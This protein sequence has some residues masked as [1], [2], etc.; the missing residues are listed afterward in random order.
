MGSK[1]SRTC[2]L[3][4]AFLISFF[5]KT[6]NPT[7]FEF[8]KGA[9]ESFYYKPFR[10]VSHILSFLNGCCWQLLCNQIV[11]DWA[12]TD[13]IVAVELL[14]QEQTWV[15]RFASAKLPIQRV[16]HVEALP[17]STHLRLSLLEFET[18]QK[19]I[20]TLSTLSRLVEFVDNSYTNNP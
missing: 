1:E 2:R 18:E 5:H 14:Q 20:D 7:I 3:K 6:T 15:T 11:W 19:R 8:P 10:I 17:R 12:T 13:Q 4:N 9:T 16:A